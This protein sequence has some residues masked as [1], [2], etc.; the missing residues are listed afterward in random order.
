M[1][2]CES[3]KYMR[4]LTKMFGALSDANRLRI[5]KMLE[6]KPMCVCEITSV[7]KLAPSTVSKHLTILRDSELIHDD[8]DGKWVQYS[9]NNNT[10]EKEIKDIL[11]IIRNSLNETKQAIDDIKK[12]KTISRKDICS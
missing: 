7:L 8:K 4:K 11:K 3:E 10:A 12:A 1:T 6:G 9:L 5:L 2:N